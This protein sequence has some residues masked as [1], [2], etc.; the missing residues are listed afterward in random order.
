MNKKFQPADVIKGILKWIVVSALGFVYW[1]AVL[2]LASLFLMNIWKTSFDA[3]LQYG[4]ILAVITSVIYGG[5]LI[6][7]GLK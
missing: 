4:I 7:K 5:N 1:M 3:I 2:L 6:Y